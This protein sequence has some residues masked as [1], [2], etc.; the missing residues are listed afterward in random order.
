MGPLMYLTSAPTRAKGETKE[1]RARAMA[2]EAGVTE[3]LVCILS[4]LET[5]MSFVVR[6]NPQT[7]KLE[8][9]RQIRKCLHY[10]VYYLDPEFGLMHIRIQSWF[11]FNL[12]IYINGREW[13]ARQLDQRGIA[14]QRADNKL[15]QIA[16]LEAAFRQLGFGGYYWVNEDVS[17]VFGIL[18]DFQVACADK[19]TAPVA[20][21]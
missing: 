13:L 15:F 17:G 19:T 2:A 6:G 16:D 3:G 21:I 20:G 9:V 1:D 18:E 10:Y 8:A 12:Q 4:V 11:P 14:Y 7:H 5:C